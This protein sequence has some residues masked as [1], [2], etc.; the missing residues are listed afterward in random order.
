MGGGWEW[1]QSHRGLNSKYQA[2]TAVILLENQLLCPQSGYSNIHSDAV[3]SSLLGTII[4]SKIL[5]I[6]MTG[7]LGTT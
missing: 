6:Q 1:S 7:V 2:F 4:I 3:K 5:M